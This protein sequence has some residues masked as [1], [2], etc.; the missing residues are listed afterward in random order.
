MSSP[1]A[2]SA[3]ILLNLFHSFLCQGLL[4]TGL[5]VRRKGRE[6][7][8]WKFN[9][10]ENMLLVKLLI[11]IVCYIRLFVWLSNQLIWFKIWAIHE[12]ILWGFALYSSIYHW[13]PPVEETGRYFFLPSGDIFMYK[14]INLSIIYLLSSSVYHLSLVSHQSIISHLSIII[15]LYQYT[16]PLSFPQDKP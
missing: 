6:K 10:L 3:A 16:F 2:L 12:N 4:G 14:T 15:C 5:S 9:E 13:V 11:N 7:V 1:F 8:L